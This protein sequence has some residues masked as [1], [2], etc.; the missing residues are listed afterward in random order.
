MTKSSF[1]PD[2]WSDCFL[3]LLSERLVSKPP[4]A[5]SSTNDVLLQVLELPLKCLLL[6]FCV[7]NPFSSL[8]HHVKSCDKT[9]LH[10]ARAIWL[11]CGFL[12]MKVHVFTACVPRPFPSQFKGRGVSRLWRI[13]LAEGSHFGQWLRPTQPYIGRLA[14]PNRGSKNCIHWNQLKKFMQI[15]VD[16]ECM[17]TNFGE[18]GF[19]SF[20]VKVWRRFP[21]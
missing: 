20:E 18:C 6:Q 8:W 3:A 4:T 15:G 21:F 10:V 1:P 7:N 2:E 9:K 12:C 13:M 11:G 5:G 14:P 19:F 17:H 16:V